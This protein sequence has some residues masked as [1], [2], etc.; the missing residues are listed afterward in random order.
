M[1]SKRA[2]S[3]SPDTIS[4]ET[5][6]YSETSEDTPDDSSDDSPDDST[7]QRQ[8]KRI[9]NNPKIDYSK[10]DQGV[11]LDDAYNQD[12]DTTV[13][14][15]QV[16]QA[17]YK[18]PE[19]Y[20]AWK[21]GL[22]DEERPVY[23]IILS[24][25]KKRAVSEIDI[26]RS[27]MTIDD[28]IASYEILRVMQNELKLYGESDNWLKLRIR[29][30]D[31]IKRSTSLS[32]TDRQLLT[33]LDDLTSN[34][35]D[36][37][38]SIIRSDHSDAVKA[39]IYRKYCDVKQLKPDDETYGKTL[40]WINTALSVPTKVTSLQTTYSDSKTMIRTVY[41][42]LNS[43]VYGQHAAKER[44][45]DTVSAMWSNPQASGKCML[46]VGPPGVGK[47]AFASALASGLNLPFQQISFGGR[48]DP[49]TLSGHSFTYVGSK[50]GEIAQSLIKMGVLNGVLLLD[51]ID[52][53]D[54][55]GQAIS[56]MLLHILDYDQ[57][58]SFKDNYLETPI[59]L[60]KLILIATAND[61][62]NMCK[63]L[64]DRIQPISFLNY[65]LQD[66]INMC[67]Q[68]II[69]KTLKNLGISNTDIVV[70]DK[71]V[72]K[73]ITMSRHYEEGVRQLTRNIRTVFERVNTLIQLGS[74]SQEVKLSYNISITLPLTLTCDHVQKL[75]CED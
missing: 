9:K 73:I 4:D 44:I 46:L 39:H 56:S 11:D 40:Q 1:T 67:Q 2:R 31:K 5:D 65:S 75:F 29:L 63:I 24:E 34:N 71:T 72:R 15:N 38:Q 7:N 74:D 30:L 66:K 55:G 33:Y 36:T 57:N 35:N 26:V 64:L 45:L 13:V 3:S 8:S 47:T 37:L 42:R 68:F 48:R 23:D 41:G 43:R 18:E 6:N 50:P 52:K 25:F 49:A 28:K 53:L 59:D 16:V 14:V 22:T 70:P 62:T 21:K 12:S 58:H 69:P 51:E 60:S 19:D 61:T 27:D 32:K 17:A 54:D 10:F 20:A